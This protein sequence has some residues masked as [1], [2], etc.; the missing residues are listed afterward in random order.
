MRPRASACRGAR[1]V[2]G[3]E[4]YSAWSGLRRRRW[5][6]AHAMRQSRAFAELR[7]PH[8]AASPRAFGAVAPRR[9]T[10]AGARVPWRS[11]APVENGRQRRGRSVSRAEGRFLGRRTLPRTGPATARE[12]ERRREPPSA[13]WTGG[14]LVGGCAACGE[15]LLNEHERE[16]RRQRGGERARCRRRA[17]RAADCGSSGSRAELP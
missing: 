1:G 4:A 5:W 9:C 12:H 11:A 7:G 16:R 17:P 15:V 10:Y 8:R 2:G 3:A 6:R 13:G 14:R